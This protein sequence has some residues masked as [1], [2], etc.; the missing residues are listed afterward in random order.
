MGGEPV[1]RLRSR[2]LLRSVQVPRPNGRRL[3]RHLHPE[4]CPDLFLPGRCDQKQ[5]QGLG[6]SG[7]RAGVNR[8]HPPGFFEVQDYLA[9]GK[10]TYHARRRWLADAGIIDPLRTGRGYEVFLRSASDEVAAVCAG[11]DRDRIL[12]VIRNPGSSFWFGV[13]VMPGR[14]REAELTSPVKRPMMGRGNTDSTAY[15]CGPFHLIL[16]V[17]VR[18]T[19]K[20]AKGCGAFMGQ[21]ERLDA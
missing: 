4:E 5:D 8:E 21:S 6:R 11:P 16:R 10:T 19:R 13:T 3:L 9:V 15:T 20:I 1:R 14:S 7:P 17:L 2:D 18:I 12:P